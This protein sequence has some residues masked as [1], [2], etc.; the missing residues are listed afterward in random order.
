VL[1]F[2]K[3]NR[4]AGTT[5]LSA[6]LHLHT[7]AQIRPLPKIPANYPEKVEIDRKMCYHLL[8]KTFRE[9]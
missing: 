7:A 1:A 9:G 8:D 2:S 5:T 6:P 4:T 3:P